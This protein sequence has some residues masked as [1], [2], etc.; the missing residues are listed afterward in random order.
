M[1]HVICRGNNG[2]R[3]FRNRL[4]FS[5]FKHTLSRYL[6]DVQ[7]YVHHYVLMNT[8]C[9]FLAWCE[10]TSALAPLIK[11]VCVSY[12]YQYCKRYSYKGHLWH[13]RFRTVVIEDEDQWAQCGRYIELNP[14]YAGACR[15]PRNYPWSSYHYY[16]T[17]GRDALIQPILMRD[18]FRLREKGDINES[19]REFVLAGIDLDYRKLKKQFEGQRSPRS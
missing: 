13:S 1:L 11:A 5:R 6:K 3:I 10:E 2:M 9:H 15:D 7:I 16:E 8:H 17:G 14:V 19:Y 12:N 4:D 18:E